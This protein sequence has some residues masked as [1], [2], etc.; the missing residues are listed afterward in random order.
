MVRS[1]VDLQARAAAPSRVLSLCFLD[2]AFWD[3]GSIA[4]K[5]PAELVMC[6][7]VGLRAGPIPIWLIETGSHIGNFHS[8]TPVGMK[9]KAPVSSFHMN[10]RECSQRTDEREAL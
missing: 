10:I 8:T 9:E 3:M 1:L 4:S 5:G 2:R 6:I 7:V